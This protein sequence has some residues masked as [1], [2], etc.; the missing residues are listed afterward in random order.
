MGYTDESDVD[1]ARATLGGYERGCNVT[2]WLKVFLSGV[3]GT[4]KNG[5][6]GIPQVKKI[7]MATIGDRIRDCAGKGSN[8]RLV[9]VYCWPL[10]FWGGFV[11]LRACRARC[12][13]SIPVRSITSWIEGTGARTFFSM[14]LIVRS[15]SRRWLRLAKRPAGR[16]M[17]TA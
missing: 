2:V 10:T 1:T 5:C 13:W 9:L 7:I 4:M 8:R 16:C 6:S 17:R 11:F 14:M 3:A 15:C 12:E